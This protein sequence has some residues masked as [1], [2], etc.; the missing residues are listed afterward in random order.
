M[1]LTFSKKLSLLLIYSLPVLLITGP[2]LPDISIS[3]IGLL[4]IIYAIY[5]KKIYTIKEKWVFIGIVFWIYLQISSLFAE[6]ISLS[7]RDSTIFE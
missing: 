3:I 6:N 5:E 4:F 1:T 2:A 7:F